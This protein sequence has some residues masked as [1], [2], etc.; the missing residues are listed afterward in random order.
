MTRQRASSGG[1]SVEN[2]R[3]LMH[4]RKAARVLPVPV[5]A[6]TSVE[7]P[8]AMAGQ[9]S[10]CGRVGP[11][12]T[13]E[14]QSRTAGWKRSR[15]F[16]RGTAGTDA[17]PSAKGCVTSADFGGAFLEFRFGTFESI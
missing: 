9:P 6:K 3:R 14:N 2:I 15:A 10:V 17:G 7:S 8:R 4:Q 11:M 12:K 13:A 16:A 5:G 1:L